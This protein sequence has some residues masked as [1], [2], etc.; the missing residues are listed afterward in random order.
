M[1]FY[2]HFPSKAMLVAEYLAY[3]DEAWRQLLARF[4]GDESKPPLDRLLAVFDALAVFTQDPKFRGCP[5][6]KS[7]AE[8]GPERDDPEIRRMITA[9][10]A[11]AEK[12]VAGLVRH[13]RPKDSKKFVQ[14][15]LSLITGTVVVA[16]S[17]GRTDVALRNKELVKLLLSR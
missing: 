1:T 9:H 6:I 17:S 13:I 12:F 11:D 5:F 7:L 4:A 3:K 10:F 2:R 16:Q 8:F 14:P 15:I